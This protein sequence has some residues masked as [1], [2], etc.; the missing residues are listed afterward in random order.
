M[1]LAWLHHTGAFGPK[2]DLEKDLDVQW[3]QSALELDNTNGRTWY[4]LGRC[5]ASLNRV[6]EAFSAYRSS[7]DKTEAS[8]DTWLVFNKFSL[9]NFF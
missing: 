4:L 6:Q 1:L 8:A 3:L 5:Q 7:I 9:I 2:S